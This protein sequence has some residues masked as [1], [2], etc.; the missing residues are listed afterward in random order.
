MIL[1]K[2]GSVTKLDKRNGTTSKNF[3]ND[4]TTESC[5]AIAILSS[6]SQFNSNF[7]SYK[8]LKHNWKISNTALT[9]LLSVKV[10]FL[11]KHADFLQKMLTSAKLRKSW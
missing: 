4:I 2:P 6:H 10:L 8:K 3:D 5:A 9:P 11:S 7:L 1:T